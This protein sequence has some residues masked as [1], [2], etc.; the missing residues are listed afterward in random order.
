[1]RRAIHEAKS[2]FVTFTRLSG[3]PAAPRRTRCVKIEVDIDTRHNVRLRLF[4]S[5]SISMSS[6]CLQD[7]VTGFFTSA[8]SEDHPQA[9]A[10]DREDIAM[11]DGPASSPEVAT[12]VALPVSHFPKQAIV[13]IHGMGEQMPMDTI[14]G[15]V[16][17]VWETE[18]GLAFEDKD[19]PN[20][21]AVWSKPDVRTGSLELRR[22][23]TRQS[24]K[25]DTFDPGV[26]SDFYE[27]YWADLSGG[28]TWSQ[29]QDWIFAL[30][31]RN[32]FTR[33]PPDVFLAWIVLWIITL[34]V[35]LFLIA[36]GLKD[37]TTIG[38]YNVWDYLPLRWL[39]GFQGWA[40]TAVGV[41]FGAISTRYI[42]PYFG[43]VVRYT[44]AKPDN[45]AARK[46]IRERGLE[47][48]TELHEVR[49]HEGGY[50]RIIVVGHSLGSMLAYDLIS[51]FWAKRPEA[52]VLIEGTN[53]FEA[54]REMEAVLDHQEWQNASKAAISETPVSKAAVSKEVI[55]RY[56]KAQTRLGHLLRCR[57]KPADKAADTRWLISD[58]I[59][60]GSPLSH[61]EF[62]MASGKKDL[63]KRK[64]DREFPISPPLREH[65][66]PVAHDRAEAAG[67]PAATEELLAFP[68]GKNA[69]QL[70]HAALFAV[71]RW[72]NIHDPARLVAF[73]DLISGPVAPVFGEA[74]IDVDLK[75]LRGRQSWRFTHTRYWKLPRKLDSLPVRIIE[76]RK[77]LD[78]GGRLRKL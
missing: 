48:L 50:D 17:A 57:A 14:K 76:L 3:G 28:S 51:Y 6:G 39:R 10:M 25:T 40:L 8:R 20:P 21:T 27:L 67:F 22:I 73:G 13:V 12:T 49:P 42:V 34:V 9:T 29:V 36:A 60:L 55:D 41:V 70:H 16:R 32:P 71:V 35:A 19:I 37:P 26:R 47:L 63:R 15:F 69:W 64:R 23:T 62:L 77:A 4:S 65:L 31:W 45:I 66:D 74:I 18:T 61:A 68:F 43:R 54:F 24:V 58:F 75:K 59:T 33:V 5:L 7:R 46:N 1:M 38:G 72:T 53:E 30:L 2:I 11:A 78:L 52:R 56:L 44:T